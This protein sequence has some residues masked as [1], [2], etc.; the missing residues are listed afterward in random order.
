[1]IGATL[2]ADE[3]NQLRDSVYDLIDMQ[4]QLANILNPTLLAKMNQTIKSMEGALANSFARYDEAL[5]NQIVHFEQLQD[6]NDFLTFWSM[7]EIADM[8]ADHPYTGA[9]QLR[10]EYMSS[11][12]RWQPGSVVVDIRGTKWMDLWDAANRAVLESGDD[13]HIFIESFKWDQDGILS[14]STGS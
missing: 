7:H 2:T 3:F 13:H 6:T 8:D 5:T 12:S 1:M 11:H 4:K 14:L 9:S 10:Y